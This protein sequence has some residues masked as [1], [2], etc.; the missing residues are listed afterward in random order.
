MKKLLLLLLFAGFAAS[1]AAQVRFTTQSTDALHEQA[2]QQGKLV[3]IDLY[4]P[5]CPPCRAMEKQVFSRS[6]VGEF[7]NE[8]FVCAKYNVDEPT[9]KA[10]M[11][12]YEAEGVPTF[13]IFNTS[14]D[15]LGRITGAADAERFTASIRTILA[16]Q[17]PKK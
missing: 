14:G 13:L 6:D 15:L 8:R 4:A 1:T 7:M 16:R 17:R 2:L 3:F 12:K 9:G 11:K 10:L 5:W